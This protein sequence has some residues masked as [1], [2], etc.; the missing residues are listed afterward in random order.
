MLFGGVIVEDKG[1]IAVFFCTIE[2]GY[3]QLQRIEARA[4]FSIFQ[5]FDFGRQ[6]VQFVQ[7]FA[8]FGSGVFAVFIKIVGTVAQCARV[9]CLGIDVVFYDFSCAVMGKQQIGRT[10]IALMDI[11]MLG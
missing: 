5:Y 9:V 7:A 11:V 6:A 8:S 4:C 3:G 10:R 2:A 1:R